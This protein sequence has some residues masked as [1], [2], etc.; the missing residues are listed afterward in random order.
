VAV[1]QRGGIGDLAQAAPVRLERDPVL[2]ERLRPGLD[3]QRLPG[4]P[5]RG[6]FPGEAPFPVQ[7]PMPEAHRA[8]RVEHPR[9]P[10]PEEAVEVGRRAPRP[11][12]PPKHGR[13]TAPPLRPVAVRRVRLVVEVVEEAVM[14]GLELWPR[15]RSRVVVVGHAPQHVEVG[16][17]VILPGLAL[18]DLALLDPERRVDPLSV[19]RFEDAAAVADQRF[20]GAVGFDRGAQHDEV[21]GQVLPWRDRA[22]Q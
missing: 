5:D 2:D 14:D 20:G 12:H 9:G 11:M 18:V 3:G 22:G 8:V 10:Q 17:E 19:L 1:R 16:L 13:R 7:P 21:G 4:H 15:L 6:P